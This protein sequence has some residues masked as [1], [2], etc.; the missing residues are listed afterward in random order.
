MGG[1]KYENDELIQYGRPE[2]IW[3]HVEDLS[4]AH[5]YI[6]LPPEQTIDDLPEGL[7]EDCVQ[8]VKEN[9][10][11]GRKQSVTVIYTP[12]SNL[13]K[14]NTMEPGEV[15]YHDKS[16]VKKVRVEKKIGT[17][18]NRLNRSK[19]FKE[20]DEH[21]ELKEERSR[22]E[23]IENRDKKKTQI[24]MKKRKVEEEKVS[25]NQKQYVD[26]MN[27]DKMTS[28]LDMDSDY[29]DDFM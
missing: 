7:I 24:E 1:D 2:D 9:S 19:D 25:Y 10:I 4:S 26:F 13:R 15:A 27:E 18:I 12:W 3:F 16:L 20:M 14:E 5:V 29:E 11:Q 21:K 23:I 8:L 6:R 17:V 22:R 28:N